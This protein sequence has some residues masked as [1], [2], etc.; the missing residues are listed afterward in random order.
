VFHREIETTL[1]RAKETS[2]LA[3]KMITIAK[4]GTLAA[5][6]QL[7]R[8]LG[9]PEVAKELLEQIAPRLKDRK[10]GYTRVLKLGWRAG[11]GAERALIQFSDPIAIAE[12][13]KKPKKE[14]KAKAAPSPVLPKEEKKAPKPEK[15]IE[16]KPEKPVEKEEKEKRGGFLSKLRKFLKGDDT[17]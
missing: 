12:K 5:R 6:R 14:K 8:H 3:E 16:K 15:K 9:S 2:R 13:E 7:I 11:D 17:K 10:G 4:E 1:A